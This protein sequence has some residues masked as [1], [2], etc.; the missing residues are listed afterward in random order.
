[1]PL[2]CPQVRDDLA[3]PES[4]PSPSAPSEGVLVHGLYLEGA[5][6]DKVRKQ[7]TAKVQKQPNKP[8]QWPVLVHTSATRRQHDAAV[9]Y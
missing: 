1:M 2:W 4:S 6:W 8:G 3:D 9:Q 7:E 5:A